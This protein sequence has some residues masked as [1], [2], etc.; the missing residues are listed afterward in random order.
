MFKS[1]HFV[2]PAWKHTTLMFTFAQSRMWSVR[3][4]CYASTSPSLHGDTYRSQIRTL[5]D[6]STCAITSLLQWSSHRCK[7]NSLSLKYLSPIE[8]HQVS[9]YYQSFGLLIHLKCSLIFRNVELSWP[10]PYVPH[11]H[12]PK[13]R[14]NVLLISSDVSLSFTYINSFR[15]IQRSFRHILYINL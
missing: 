7:R 12:L 15:K 14:Q 2:M 11:I 1:T 8:S 4:T 13:T 9:S 3:Y 6:R 5:G 10:Q